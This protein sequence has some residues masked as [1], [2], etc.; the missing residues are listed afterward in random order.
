MLVDV[1]EVSTGQPYSDSFLLEIFAS[2]TTTSPVQT[3]KL[4][5]ESTTSSTLSRLL[6]TIICIK[7]L[8][9]SPLLFPG[10]IRSPIFPPIFPSPDGGPRSDP[11]GEV[12]VDQVGNELGEG[13][14]EPREVVNCVSNNGE[15]EGETI[16]R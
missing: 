4:P 10:T 15:S 3:H 6:W 7:C 1:F 5:V 12:N 16:A 2:R 14:E 11:L 13:A 8:S 9:P